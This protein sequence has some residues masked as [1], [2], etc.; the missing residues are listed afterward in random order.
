MVDA[1][2]LTPLAGVAFARYND[3]G[4]TEKG[5]TNQ[6]LTIS[7]GAT[8]RFEGVLG[9][10]VQFDASNMDDMVVTP[11]AHGFVRHDFI[12]KNGETNIKLD[13][14]PL[15]PKSVKP[16]NTLF[17]VGIGVNAKSDMYEFGVG[18]DV[19][20]AKDYVSHQGTLKVRLNF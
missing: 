8:N 13:G 1:V 5:T 11:E 6:N 7:R 15:T 10:R 9:A 4:Y 19:N 17:N 14:L 18:Y 2:T 20:L 3:G 12:G 16:N